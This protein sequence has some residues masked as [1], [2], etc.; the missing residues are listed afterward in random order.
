MLTNEQNK[1]VE[2]HVKALGPVLDQINP[3]HRN[4]IKA[5]VEIAVSNEGIIP[6]NHSHH[7]LAAAYL[8]RDL[9][10]IETESR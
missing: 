1:K 2:D 9:S 6:P 5:L 4:K 3:Y 8:I 7:L 10:P